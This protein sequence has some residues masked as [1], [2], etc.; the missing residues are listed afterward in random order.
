[1]SSW[2]RHA[3]AVALAMLLTLGLAGCGEPSKADL[4]EQA[5]DASSKAA[6]RDALGNP[7]DISKLGPVEKW[8]YT[9]SDGSVVFVITGDD[10]VVQAA[11]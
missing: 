8:T 9:A 11:N 3:G 10:I 2:S 4:V 5:Q 6:L 7:D 1:M